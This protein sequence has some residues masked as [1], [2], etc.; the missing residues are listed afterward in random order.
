MVYPEMNSGR[1]AAGT[2]V[3]NRTAYRSCAGKTEKSTA[4]EYHDSKFS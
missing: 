2:R 3:E 4:I 1:R